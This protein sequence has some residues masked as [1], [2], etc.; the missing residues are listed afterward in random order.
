MKSWRFMTAVALILFPLAAHART[1]VVVN[2]AGNACE[3]LN[4]MSRILGR[5]IASPQD[6]V[7]FARG[8]GQVTTTTAKTLADGEL[9]VTVSTSTGGNI[10]VSNLDDCNKL[11][12]WLHSQG[13]V[14]SEDQLR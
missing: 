8:A 11:V 12:A 13:G 7:D 14:A 2:P 3:N 5:H 4:R 1:W 9:M 10:F 6:L